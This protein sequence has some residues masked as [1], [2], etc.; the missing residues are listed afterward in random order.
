LYQQALIKLKEEL[1]EEDFERKMKS[2]C[3]ILI[4]IVSDT[5]E[6]LEFEEQTNSYK[7]LGISVNYGI[8]KSVLVALGSVAFAVIQSKLKS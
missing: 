3:E 8:L 6:E 5:I 1:G 2:R 4:A 7:V